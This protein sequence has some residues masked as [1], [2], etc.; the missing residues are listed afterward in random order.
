MAEIKKA[1]VSEKGH[2][3]TGKV[4]ILYGNVK[5]ISPDGTVRLLKIN[6]PVFADDRIITGDDGSVSIVFS[7]F[8]PTQ[9]DLGRVSDVVID[10]DVYGAASPEIVAEASAEKDA[11]QEALLAGDQPLEL[12][13]TAAGVEQ[14][15]GGGHTVFVVNP[16]WIHVT[17]ESGAETIGI[18]WGFPET[19]EYSPVQED[20]SPPTITVYT[21]NDAGTGVDGGD[22]GD[23]G[24]GNVIGS[25][26]VV[27][28]SGL[29][30]GSNAA[31]NT[32][33]AAGSFI[34]SDP[35]GLDDIQSVTINGTEITINNLSG[36]VITGTN[37]ILTI[38][39]YNSATGVGTYTYE[40]TKPT[41]DGPGVETEVFT[42]TTSD[43]TSTSDEAKIT[44]E[45]SDD[46]PHA[47][48]DTNSIVEDTTTAITG[49][50]LSN[51]VSGADSPASFVNWAGTAATYGTFADTGNGNYSYL[52]DNTNP[53]VQGL[54]S[55]ETLTETFTYTMQDADGDPSSSTLKITITG[56]NDGPR[57]TTDQGNPGG[58][59]DI[60]NEAGLPNGSSAG[61]GSVYASGT[62]TI[63][64]PDGLDDI[65]SVT[66]NGVTI[67]IES[68]GTGN[69]IPGGTIGNLIITD[70]DP[71]TG[72]ANYTYELKTPTTD[73]PAV[74]ETDVFTL[75][76]S[77]GTSTSAPA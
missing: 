38:T 70:Y 39:G 65:Q 25:N 73:V 6:S 8:P 55:G 7:T 10:E 62:F 40:L 43:G 21:G 19:E 53:L 60:V 29:P 77:D 71:S 69:V 2:Q 58:A 12:D 50:V 37:G 67:P 15:A 76:T 64:D 54:D 51:D 32:E 22:S 41:T 18:K 23:G 75:T 57:I 68:L 3:V 28:E 61:D 20:N 11:I 17:P 63:S 24:T 42:L 33:F 34:I 44:I 47:V 35:D 66:I 1:E 9:L 5:A 74:T 59:N 52:L 45:I 72:V 13:P 14:N 48:A 56:T 36:T 49:N 31:A 27:Y 4:A 16:D 30:A 46:V 26:D